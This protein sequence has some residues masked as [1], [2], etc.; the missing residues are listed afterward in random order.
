MRVITYGRR[1]FAISVPC[2]WNDL[3][4]TLR[5][6]PD[7]L[8]QFQSTLKIMLFCVFV[9]S[10]VQMKRVA[11]TEKRRS[12]HRVSLVCCGRPHRSF[13]QFC[14]TTWTLLLVVS[15]LLL[16]DSGTRFLWTVELLHL[17]THL[18]SGLRH[19]SLFHHHH[20]HHQ[21]I[22]SRRKSYK[23]FRAAMCHVF[24]HNPHCSTR[25]CT[26]ARYKCID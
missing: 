4:P 17:L 21:R 3:P 25:L 23:N 16:Q 18:R 6:S 19:F 14:R 5:A 13:C 11:A 15:L 9:F 7:T 20:H 1:S 12:A 24:Q 8:R 26:M 2:V 22:S 10:T